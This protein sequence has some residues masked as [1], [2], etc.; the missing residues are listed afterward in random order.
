M[1]CMF[2]DPRKAALRHRRLCFC[3]FPGRRVLELGLEAGGEHREDLE[4]GLL[5]HVL[6]HV[7]L[8]TTYFVFVCW[9]CVVC[10]LFL[11]TLLV[12]LFMICLV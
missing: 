9:F 3:C 2:M 11:F 7:C 10:P 1:L 6:A 8:F 4:F 5:D 12:C